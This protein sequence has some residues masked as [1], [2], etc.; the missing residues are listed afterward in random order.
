[1]LRCKT[2]AA[3]SRKEKED[4]FKCCEDF[5][6]SPRTGKQPPGFSH[7]RLSVSRAVKTSVQPIPPRL[8]R[9]PVTSLLYMIVILYVMSV[10]AGHAIT[11]FEEETSNVRSAPSAPVARLC[12]GARPYCSH[13]P[14]SGDAGFCG[15]KCTGQRSSDW[16]RHECH[17]GTP[18]QMDGERRTVRLDQT[19]PQANPIALKRPSAHCSAS[20]QSAAKAIR[21]SCV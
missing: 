11:M 4:K 2:L 7:Q 13:I 18:L 15:D 6:L 17:G 9:P 12:V 21:P 8:R 14:A 10:I 3:C 20:E 5:H 1:M 16:C 19:R